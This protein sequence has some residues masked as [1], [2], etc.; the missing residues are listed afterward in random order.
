MEKFCERLKELRLEKNLSTVA[1]AKEI[2]VQNSTIQR[3]EKGQ[4]IPGIDMLIK[5][6]NYFQVSADYM[7]GLTD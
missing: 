1:L 3:W 7:L 4:R 2:D 6:C 5:I